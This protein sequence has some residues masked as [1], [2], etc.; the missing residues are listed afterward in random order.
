MRA[1]VLPIVLIFC[2]AIARPGSAQSVGDV[3][4]IAM[5]A[6]SGRAAAGM[7]VEL[8]EVSGDTLRLAAQAS[9]GEDGRATLIASGPLPLGSYELRFQMA[10]YFRREGVFVGEPAVIDYAP[11]RF[12]ITDPR[13][14][15]HV[16]LICTP[17][18]YTTYRG[19]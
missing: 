9:T 2:A 6:V 3:S 18:G 16:P 8:Y 12:S 10:E 5:N 1:F 7:T 19:S 15:Y 4:T 11:V 17:S 14:H 13:G